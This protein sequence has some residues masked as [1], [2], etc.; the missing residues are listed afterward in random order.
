MEK[1]KTKDEGINPSIFSNKTLIELDTCY[2][3]KAVIELTKI[4]TEE[5]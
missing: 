1:E 3:D 4:L 5:D 2:V